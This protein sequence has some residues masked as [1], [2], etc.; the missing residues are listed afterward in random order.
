MPLLP[1]RLHTRLL[2]AVILAMVAGTLGLSFWTASSQS[3]QLMQDRHHQVELLSRNIAEGSAHHYVVEDY[4]ALELY[5]RQTARLPRV[6][7]I[8]A[9]DAQGK[10]LAAIQRPSADAPATLIP[11]PPSVV[12]PSSVLQSIRHVDDQ[13][14][15]WQPVVAGSLLGWIEISYGLDDIRTLQLQTWRNGI[16]LSIVEVLCGTI[17]FMLL[18]KRPVT[19]LVQ[20]AAFAR[21]L[22]H[23]KGATI[24]V[25]LS[26]LEV[27]ELGNALNHASRE[28]LRV[29]QELLELNRTLE[30]RVEQELAKSREKD[31]LLLQQARFQTLGELLVNISHQWRQPLNAIASLLQEQAYRISTGE[32]APHGAPDSIT[33]PLQILRGL[34][35][36][37]EGFRQLCHPAAAQGSFLPSEAV[38]RAIAMV[39]EGYRQQGIELTLTVVSEHPLCGTQQDMVQCLLNLLSNARDAISA[40]SSQGGAV[41]ILLAVVAGN[42][43]ITLTDTGG[44]IPQQ[45]LSTLFDP[46][47]TSKFRSQGVGL[48]LFVVRQIVEQRFHG[49][50]TARNREEGAELTMDLPLAQGACP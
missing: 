19:S 47:V 50:V 35:R 9:A 28:L 33:E 15:A 37:I 20:L 5:L 44:G 25:D 23:R 29:E 3:E 2:M 18:L 32:I 27:A 49:T 1:N 26:L 8:I 21:E 39:E 38:E 7:R 10:V 17:L 48:G 36:S 22:P 14:T 41:A 12:P 34:S 40:T 13:L 4:A 6:Y 45:L 24:E 43:R 31:L 11:G 46:Y 16:V 42:Q 30:T